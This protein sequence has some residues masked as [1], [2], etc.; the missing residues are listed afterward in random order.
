MS[1]FHER[2]FE[3][4]NDLADYPAAR[5]DAALAHLFRELLTLVEADDARWCLSV[6]LAARENAQ[7]DLCL[8]W[9]VR[10][11]VPASP[12]PELLARFH[13]FLQH[14]VKQNL[15][16][17]GHTTVHVLRGSGAFRIYTL[18]GPGFLDFEEFR[19]TEHYRLY[20]EKNHLA[21]R[22]WI[23]CPVNSDVESGFV[24][25][26]FTREG[27]PFFSEH[28]RVRAEMILRGLKWFNRRLVLS[29]G[30]IAGK[31][32][33]TPAERKTLGLLLTGKSEKEIAQELAV[34]VGTAHNR[35]TTIFKKFAVRSRAELMALW[36]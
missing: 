14:A 10:D 2:V 1:D 16:H 27:R 28:D 13:H 22:M 18:R 32:P 4:W 33:C 30:V 29:R 12:T 26:R 15:E 25:D 19:Q 8:G 11:L 23:G 17:I 31:T 5:T 24:L 7:N 21:D 20:Y 9:R 36:L 35:I 34:S 6:R 3:L